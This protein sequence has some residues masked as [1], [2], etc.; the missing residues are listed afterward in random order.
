MVV[1]GFFTS[2]AQYRAI[3]GVNLRKVYTCIII[4]VCLSAF[5]FACCSGEYETDKLVRDSF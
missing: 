2:C 3:H 5:I 1:G 4:D